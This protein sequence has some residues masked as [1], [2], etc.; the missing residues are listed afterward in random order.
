VRFVVVAREAFRSV[1]VPEAE[2]RSEIV[3]LLIVVVA[4]VEVPVTTKVLVVVAFVVVRLSMN[5]V[6]AERKV[7]KKLVEV[8]LSKK[9]CAWYSRIA[10]HSFSWFIGLFL[11]LQSTY[12]TCPWWTSRAA[13]QTETD[14]NGPAQRDYAVTFPSRIAYLS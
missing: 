13:R 12:R 4:R 3:A 6:A 8:A 7:A 1:I 14:T 10:P 9:T 2:V 11:S 5:A